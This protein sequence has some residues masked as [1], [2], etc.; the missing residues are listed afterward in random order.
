[1]QAAALGIAVLSVLVSSY[2]SAQGTGTFEAGAFA[3]ASYF[4]RSLRF[5]QAAGGG[6][7]RLGIFLSR[8]IELEADGAFV[9]TDGPEGI[10]VYYLPFRARLLLNI[11]AGTHTALL[12]GGGYVHNEYRHD[13][14]FNDDG[15]TALCR[16]SGSAFGAFPRSASAATSTISRRPPTGP[17]TTS[18]GASRSA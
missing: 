4:D 10:K 16:A 12:L 6:G 9:P 7:A 18:T 14:D 13:A 5:E 11:P 17:R 3:Q 8:H 2:A 1:M 15:A